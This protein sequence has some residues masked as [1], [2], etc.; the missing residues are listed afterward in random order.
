MA[1]SK[2]SSTFLNLDNA[3]GNIEDAKKHAQKK[4]LGDGFD[5]IV[6]D[7][8]GDDLRDTPATDSVGHPLSKETK[9]KKKS[10]AQRAA[11]GEVQKRQIVFSNDVLKAIKQEQAERL[12][13][14]PTLSDIIDEALRAR[15]DL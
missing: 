14:K 13:E 4:S 11:S 3:K 7:P 1:L 5:L 9:S 15:Y 10:E 6:T 12:D 8:K 2:P